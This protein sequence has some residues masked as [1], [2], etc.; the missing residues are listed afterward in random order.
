MDLLHLH[1]SRLPLAD[2]R[3]DG[4]AGRFCSMLS[5]SQ[6]DRLVLGSDLNRSGSG[7]EDGGV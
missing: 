3:A 5:L 7:F 4:S 1:W 2:R 6:A